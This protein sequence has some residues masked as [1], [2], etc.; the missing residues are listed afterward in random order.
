M[1]DNEKIINEINFGNTLARAF[2]CAGIKYSEKIIDSLRAL[3]A[4][5]LTENEK[6]NLTAITAPEDIIIKHYLDSAAAAGYIPEGSR[7]IDVG[8]GAGFPGIVLSI[9]REDLSLT[10]LEGSAKKAAYLE[11]ALSLLGIPQERARAVCGRA[12][13][14]KNSPALAGYFDFAVSRAV[15]PLGKLSSWCLP[16]VRKGGFLIAYKGSK[17]A[18]EYAEAAKEIHKSGGCAARIVTYELSGDGYKNINGFSLPEQCPGTGY[19]RSLV[20]VEKM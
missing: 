12:E 9:L 4:Y 13:E 14:Q 8:S 15:A 5:M 10:M 6:Y 19:N 18:E 1:N 11:G 2:E 20:F 3:T 17:G 7:I 16:F